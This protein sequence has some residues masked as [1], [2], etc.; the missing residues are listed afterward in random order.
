MSEEVSIQIPSFPPFTLRSS[1][2][3]K[4]P[5]IWVHLLES[6]IKLFSYLIND[7]FQY[8]SIKSKQQLFQF[9]KNYLFEIYGE[10]SKIFSLGAINPDIRENERI[11]KEVVFH[12]I[13]TYSILKLNLIGES[14]WY[15]IGIYIDGN[16]STVRGLVDGSYKSK[17]NDNKKSGKIS[18]I[19]SVHTYLQ[20][21]IMNGNFTSDDLTILSQLLGQ[22]IN[23][24]T[25]V[26]LKGGEIKKSIN[27]KKSIEFVEK[28]VDKN[29]IEILE[30]LFANGRGIHHKISSEIMV[31][32]LISLP[33][34]QISKLLNDLKI[35]K[36]SSM[37]SCPLFTSIVI[38][39][40]FN[41]LIPI[42]EKIPHL[43]NGLE[44][45]KVVKQEDIDTLVGIFPDLTIGKAKTILIDN[46]LNVEKVTNILLENPEV[47]KFIEEE[48]EE[49]KQTEILKPTES[50]SAR[51][52]SEKLSYTKLSKKTLDTKSLKE[53][54][55]VA[56]LRMMQESDDEPDDTYDVQDAGV[57]EEGGAT[58]P[59][60]KAFSNEELF[61]FSVFKKDGNEPFEKTSR[62]SSHR[63]LLKKQT[64]W[65]DEQLEGWFKQLLKSPRRYKL[66]EENYLFGDGNPN[67]TRKE[68]VSGQEVS[69]ENITTATKEKEPIKKDIKNNKKEEK[70]PEKKEVKKT[71]LNKKNNHNR[72]SGHSK[73]TRNE[74]NV[75]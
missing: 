15:F 36:T 50:E 23:K 38:S 20:K 1:L 27:K 74:L 26:D 67:R 16:Q 32:S 73:K 18:S 31:I 10:K 4:D 56:A 39:E 45:V 61:L 54:T 62:K 12:F 49:L 7:N 30:K 52:D 43:L 9:L 25:T 3:D 24:S 41:E 70:K 42:H 19:S 21:K 60:Q 46:D 64:K 40:E 29:W 72:K 47:I 44:D 5:V 59:I 51:F 68:P 2:I 28:F 65:S 8:L 55:L 66:L 33:A 69:D 53:R 35:T 14:I 71:P 58:T 75:N 22:S 57:V 34:T 17:L 37:I 13:K 6:Y 63:T 11:L 48:P